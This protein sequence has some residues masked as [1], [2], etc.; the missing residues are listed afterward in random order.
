MILETEIHS[1]SQ[2]CTK[3]YTV[4]NKLPKKRRYILDIVEKR[5]AK[6]KIIYRTN[7]TEENL[8][9]FIYIESS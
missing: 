6:R 3:S 1:S 5:C 8:T 9:H 2:F 7:T 4:I